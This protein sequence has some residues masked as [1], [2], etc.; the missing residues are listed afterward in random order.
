MPDAV[1]HIWPQC[2]ESLPD[3]RLSSLLP[4]AMIFS[5]LQ[6]SFGLSASLE[7]LPAKAGETTTTISGHTATSLL[8]GNTEVT[9]QKLYGGV[10]AQQGRISIDQNIAIVALAPKLDTTAPFLLRLDKNS[11]PK[12]VYNCFAQMTCLETTEIGSNINNAVNRWQPLLVQGDPAA[13]AVGASYPVINVKVNGRLYKIEVN[14]PGLR[15]SARKVL[16]MTDGENICAMDLGSYET[17]F[18]RMKRYKDGALSSVQWVKMIHVKPGGKSAIASGAARWNSGGKRSQ[19]WSTSGKTSND[20]WMDVAERRPRRFS[21][22]GGGTT[23]G[24]TGF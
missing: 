19:G 10:A 4:A 15:G 5:L 12:T 14:L 17:W 20:R 16:L 22:D 23:S 3:W 6:C 7:L 24:D 8:K 2:R 21:R 11:I 1:R 13:F 9:E 18:L